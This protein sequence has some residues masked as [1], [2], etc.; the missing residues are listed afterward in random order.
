MGMIEQ[1]RNDNTDTI[2]KFTNQHT[3]AVA[4]DATKKATFDAAVNAEEVALGLVED[5]KDHI[6]KLQ[7]KVDDKRV[8]EE[9]AEAK[10]DAAQRKAD[11]AAA[12]LEEEE[13]R[14]DDEKEFLKDVHELL[15]QLSASASLLETDLLKD[16]PASRR[17]LS[18]VDLSSLAEADPKAVQEVRDMINGLIDAGEKDRAAAQEADK[19]A[20]AELVQAKDVHQKAWDVLALAIGRVDFATVELGDLEVAAKAATKDRE[21]AQLAHEQAVDALAAAKDQLAIETARV[22][23][24]EEIF[25]Q[26]SELLATIQ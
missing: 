13:A 16:L 6:A 1:L 19:V 11:A 21:V 24:E 8:I 10:L 5:K 15:D 20:K 9:D 14:I 18:I 4:D 23:K 12:F 2:E 22:T 7:L 26:V 25:V 17:L 3:A